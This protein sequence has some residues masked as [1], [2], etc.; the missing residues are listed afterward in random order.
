VCPGRPC[1]VAAVIPCHAGG[2]VQDAVN[3]LTESNA[4]MADD[5]DLAHSSACVARYRL[6]IK[7]SGSYLKYQKLRKIISVSF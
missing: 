2:E 5:M 7:I 1:S 6:G 3:I 4:N